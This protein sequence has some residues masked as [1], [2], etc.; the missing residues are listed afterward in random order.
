VSAPHGIIKVVLLGKNVTV[1]TRWLAEKELDQWS[2][3]DRI[4]KICSDARQRFPEV[5]TTA[6]A[7]SFGIHINTQ[8]HMGVSVRRSST[9]H[10]PICGQVGVIDVEIG[11]STISAC[12][13]CL[14]MTLEVAERTPEEIVVT[15][16]HV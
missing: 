4:C 15:F 1:E 16:S 9:M 7:T 10:C 6:N 13:S 11:G 2:K 12:S 3:Q 5:V 8:G 14:K